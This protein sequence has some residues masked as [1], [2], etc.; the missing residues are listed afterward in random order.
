MVTQIPS[1]STGSTPTGRTDPETGVAAHDAG[2][3]ERVVLR[4]K[5]VRS[6][7]ATPREILIQGRRAF[8]E[9][10]DDEALGQLS[11]LIDQGIAYA[12][13]HY[14]IGIVHE[15]RGDLDEALTSLRQA[16]RLNPSYAEALLALASLHER[17]GDY[18]LSESYAQRAS[19]LTRPVDG[20]LDPTT[21]GKLANQQAALGDA[22]AQAGE[23]RDAIDEYRRALARCPNFHD[24][25]HRLG[26]AL[27]DAGL[28]FQAA[29]EFQQILSAHTG[30]L[31]SQVQLGLTFY[32]L[33]RSKEAVREWNA[34]LERDPSRDDAR[35][36]LRLVRHDAPPR[37]PSVD[38]PGWST[39]ALDATGFRA[40]DPLEDGADAD[41][42]DVLD[43]DRPDASPD[44]ELAAE[45][46]LD[47]GGETGD[48]IGGD[49]GGEIGG[50]R[51][52]DLGDP[53]ASESFRDAASPTRKS[54]DEGT[55][56]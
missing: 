44:F 52:L 56:A 12:D 14:M 17:R 3:I 11:R 9:R 38:S 34:V 32:S 28:P 1:H 53:L 10:N 37:L 4:Q 19:Q 24:I 30:M 25:R 27:R 2:S 20:Q 13:V 21:R 46:S 16:I 42:G 55:S 7:A 29:R 31:E 54:P 26:I 45:P 51:E 39:V 33:G 43:V 22:L 6:T 35:M 8:E 36:Y 15:R 50:D 48:E 49:F 41:L 18:D 23:L 40:D 5:S 47:L